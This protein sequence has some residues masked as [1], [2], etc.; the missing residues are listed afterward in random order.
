MYKDWDSFDRFVEE[1]ESAATGAQLEPVLNRFE[2]F[3][4]TLFGQVNIRAA[5]SGHPF[6][7]H[8]AGA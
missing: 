3:L 2:T 4:E 5:L 8:A 6:D 7:P 1:I